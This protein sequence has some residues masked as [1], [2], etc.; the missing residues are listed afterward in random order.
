VRQGAAA[1]DELAFGDWIAYR[2]TSL[3]GDRL[4]VRLASTCTAGCTLQ[5]RLD[6]PHGPLAA[7][8]PVHAT[9]SADTWQEQSVPLS[10]TVTGT[11]TLYLMA[12]GGPRVAALDWLTIRP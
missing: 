9:G 3:N 7:T 10:R 11:H 6:T 2:N 8:L 4:T 12:K 1:T 5:L